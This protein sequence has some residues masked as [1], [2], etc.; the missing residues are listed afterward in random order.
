MNYVSDTRYFK[1]RQL[2]K[3]KCKHCGHTQPIH[4]LLSKVV[5]D[6]CNHYIFRSELDEFKYRLK[7]SQIKEKR[8]MIYER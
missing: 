7:E 5:C 4:H 3:R 8:R 2:L 6:W 1:D